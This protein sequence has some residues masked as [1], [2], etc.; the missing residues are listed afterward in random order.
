MSAHRRAVSV[1]RG[2][3]LVNRVGRYRACNGSYLSLESIGGVAGGSC[4]IASFEGRKERVGG[5]NGA[6]VNRAFGGELNV[7]GVDGP[8]R[9]SM[10]LPVE[11]S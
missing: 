2:G 5:E 9:A 6:W 1:S 3:G 11:V 7:Q 8:E 10:G 4:A